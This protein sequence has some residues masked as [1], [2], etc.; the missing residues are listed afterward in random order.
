MEEIAPVHTPITAVLVYKER[1]EGFRSM[2][3][4][5]AIGAITVTIQAV[6]ETAYLFLNKGRYYKELVLIIISLTWSL[7]MFRT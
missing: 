7:Y 6:L 5:P 3:K 4:A 2:K 1:L